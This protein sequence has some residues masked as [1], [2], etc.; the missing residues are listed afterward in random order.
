MTRGG[1]SAPEFSWPAALCEPVRCLPDASHV[2]VALSG[3]LDSVLLLH[4]VRH[5]CGR[6]RTVQAVHINHQLQPNAD[7]TER[8]CRQLCQSLGI[9]LT[10]RRV[11]VPIKGGKQSTTGGVEEAARHARYQAFEQL[12]QPG[13]LLLMAHHGDDQAETV[14][15]RLLRGS[16]VSGLAG[17]PATRP[18]GEGDLHRPLLA[19]SRRQIDDWARQAGL[20]WIDDPSN[21]S[22]QYDRNFL[23]HSILPL[24]TARW[25]SLVKRLNHS[26]RACG[27]QEELAAALAQIHY[28]SV[29]GGE[30]RL[31]VAQMLGLTVTEQKNLLRWWITREGYHFPAVADWHQVLDDLLL[32]AEDRKP[33]LRGQGFALRRFHGWVYLV[34]DQPPEP[35]ASQRLL[36]DHPVVLGPWR[37]ALKPG[38]TPVGPPPPIRISTRRGGER[39]RP[40]P[41]GPSKPLKKWLQEQRVPPW[42][43]ARIPL[44]FEGP[45]SHGELVGVGDLWLSDKYCGEA[46]A[47]GWRIIVER[48]CD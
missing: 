20:T 23:R 18:L 22:E 31:R 40:R 1:N 32:S 11:T 25:P 7:V 47:T 36:P 42:E 30:G 28:A 45:E 12:L 29:A 48:E 27:E 15:F 46:P 4:L 10:V 5:C 2:W 9:A 3:G 6:D 13:Q 43:R 17:M 19:F 34:P 14:L 41:G 21:D 8:F 44:V 38:A 39:V 24:L 37:M 33:E 35:V 26:A 16:G